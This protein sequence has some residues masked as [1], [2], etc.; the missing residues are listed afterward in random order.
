MEAAP[1]PNGTHARPPVPAATVARPETSALLA[2]ARTMLPALEAGRPLDAATLRKS[3]TESFGA[4]DAAGAWSW[5]DACEA[6]EAAV[7]LFVQRFGRAMRR[8]AGAGPD[9][10]RRMLA[11]LEAVAALEPSHTRR[12]ED[13]VRLQQFSTPLPLAYA[14]LQAAAVRPGDTVLEPSAGTGMLAVMAEC[15]LGGS[16][17]KSLH[18]NE[19]ARARAGLLAG[20]FPGARVASVDA[21]A[22]ADRL[23]DVR[24][25]VV[26]MNPPFSATPGVDRIRRDADLRHVRSAFSM[27]PPGGRLAAITS[28]GCMP[29]DAAWT[30]AFRRLVPPARCVFTMAID[31]RA[32]ARRGTGSATRLT[33]LERSAEPGIAVDRASRAGDA[34]ELLDAIMPRVPP[35]LPVTPVAPVAPVP[36]PAV[37]SPDLFGKISDPAPAKRRKSGVAATPRTRQA[38]DWGPVSELAV[39]SGPDGSAAPVAANAEIAGSGPYAPWRPGAVRIPGAVAHPT[40]LVQSAAMAAVPQPVPTFRPM[41]PERV[42][43]QGLLSDAQLESVVLAGEA[44][45]RRLAAT[46]RVG[47]GWETVERCDEDADDV[48]AVTSDGE[49][50]SAPVRF[51]RGWMLG[52]GTG[53]GKGRQVAAIILDSRLRGRTRALWLSQSD[54]LLEDARRDWTAL[55]G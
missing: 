36:A 47:S 15:A 10:P 19:I 9:G 3:M 39:D 52:D 20:L 22:V 13:Q 48:A 18:L 7:V 31:G 23:P 55:G 42:V 45:S 37:P 50:L 17:G 32:Y 41:L 11:M 5:K 40:P 29:G 44:H 30:D 6:A 43:S 16:A 4:S 54:K 46:F 24:P 38:H 34:A 51:R 1:R 53:C 14:A 27:L 2:A 28:E 49:E 25:T 26:M 21:E 12:S 35:R 33:V 8:S